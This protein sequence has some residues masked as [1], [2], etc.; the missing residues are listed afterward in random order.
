MTDSMTSMKI[1]DAG[2]VAIAGC[3]AEGRHSLKDVCLFL[4]EYASWLLGS[5]ATCI[6]LERNVNRMAAA[7][8]CEAVMTILPRH[9]HMTV[10]LP[11]RADS[12]TYIIATRSMAISFDINTRLSQLSW[13]IADGKVDFASAKE[14]FSEAVGARGADKRLVLLLAACANA[15]FCRLFNGDW[16]AVAVVFLSTMAGYYLKQVMCEHKADMRVV[17]IVCAFVSSVLGATDA[18]FHLGSTPEIAVGTSVLYLVPGIPYL[19]SFSDMIAGHYI[20]SFSRF[21]HAVILTCC[22]S[23][24][25][26]GGMLLMNMGMF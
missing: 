4:S 8:G 20:C 17:F 25:L 23:I 26:C 9:I 22:L 1:D 19:N 13:A 5:G 7:W 10:A 3:E 18:L 11:D 2:P 15:A 14:R 24:G 16:Q 6:R 21:L 12:Y